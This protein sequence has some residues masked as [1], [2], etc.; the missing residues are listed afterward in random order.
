V[1]FTRKYIYIANFWSYSIIK[2]KTYYK[3]F[4]SR[5][6]ADACCNQREKRL[7]GRGKSAFIPQ[8]NL[9]GE[10]IRGLAYVLPAPI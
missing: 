9:L 6:M 7:M 4:H 2:G 8:M 5:L 10:P 1:N 3:D